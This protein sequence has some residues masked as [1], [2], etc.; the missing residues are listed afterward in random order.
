MA[1]DVHA[2]CV[3]HSS[4]DMTAFGEGLSR[5]NLSP[6]T[7]CSGVTCPPDLALAPGPSPSRRPSRRPSSGPNLLCRGTSYSVAGCPG[8]QVTTGDSLLRDRPNKL[9]EDVFLFL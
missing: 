8:G 5:S 6:G 9:S 4:V 3:Y 2:G 1:V 7:L